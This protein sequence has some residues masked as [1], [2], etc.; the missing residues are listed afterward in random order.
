M[1]KKG[2]ANRKGFSKKQK[3]GLAGILVLLIFSLV[4]SANENFFRS[5]S[6]PTWKT[7]FQSFGLA[8]KPLAETVDGE[9][10][11][12]FIDVG[13]GDSSLILTSK[14]A[15][16]IDS[17]EAENAPTVIS[18]LQALGVEKIDY[19]I[20]T[21]PHS[22]HIGGFSKIIPEFEVGEVIMPVLDDSVIPTTSSFVNMLEAIE[23]GGIKASSVMAGERLE[24]DNGLYIEIVAPAKIYTDLN[25]SSVV[26]RFVHGEN[27]FLFTGDIEAE[28]EADI[29]ETRVDISA[30]VLKIPHH[31]SRTSSTKAFVRAVSPSY[32]VYCTGADNS[33]GHPHDEVVE[34]Y[35]NFGVKTLRSDIHGNIVF[36]SDGESL[37]LR[38][39]KGEF[40]GEAA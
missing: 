33:Y 15:V 2:R 19:I 34:R 39:E 23:N 27:S 9:V 8:K 10:S 5:P 18:Y 30:D 11:V 24:L 14:S 1:T 31:G 17:G 22:D 20:A 4:I 16:L 28:A 40:Y 38:F 25:N 6:I 37:S 26:A 3:S 21:H 32:G 36:I 7:I 13:Q 29:L 35:D 12:H